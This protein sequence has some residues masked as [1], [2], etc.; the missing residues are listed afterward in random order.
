[1][2]TPKQERRGSVRDRRVNERD[3]RARPRDGGPDRRQSNRRPD[4][5]AFEIVACPAPEPTLQ[6]E[7]KLKH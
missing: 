7:V 1:M 5:L 2:Q 4:C 6:F 3:R